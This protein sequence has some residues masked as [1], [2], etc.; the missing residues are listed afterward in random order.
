[1]GE[2]ESSPEGHQNEQNYAASGGGRLG[3]LLENTRDQ[4]GERLSGLNEGDL[5]QNALQWGEG[6]CRAY[7]Q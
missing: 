5:S 6:T 3:D 4:G 2:Q 7:L 1:M